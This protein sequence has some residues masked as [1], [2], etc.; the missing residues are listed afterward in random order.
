MSVLRGALEEFLGEVYPEGLHD[1]LRTQLD[2]VFMMGAAA[3]LGCSDR[4][5]AIAELSIWNYQNKLK[6]NK[7]KAARAR[8]SVVIGPMGHS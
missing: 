6:A 8:G 7:L 1:D 3:A 2:C 4:A 5:G